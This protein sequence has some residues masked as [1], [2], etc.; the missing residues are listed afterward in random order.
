MFF[1][2][3]AYK[4][5]IFLIRKALRNKAFMSYLCIFWGY[6]PVLSSSFFASFNLGSLL[7]VIDQYHTT[8]SNPN[9]FKN[10]IIIYSHLKCRS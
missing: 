10:Q 5:V 1:G 8:S 7:T 3:F 6:K 2:H 4:W 9:G